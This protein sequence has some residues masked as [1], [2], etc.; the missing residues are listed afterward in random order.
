MDKLKHLMKPIANRVKLVVGKAIVRLIDDEMRMQTMQVEA[1]RGEVLE[2][3][4]RYQQYGFSS[5]PH[6]GSE[7]L[8]LA[9]NGMRQHSVIVAVDDRRHR[10]QMLEEGE[11]A[12]YT[13]LDADTGQRI[14]L[15]RNGS[16]EIH[17]SGSSITV[18]DGNIE[19]NANSVNIT[20]S[21]LTHNGTNVGD[22]HV[23]G[24]IMAGSG[25]TS[26]PQ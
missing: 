17:S 15:K 10:I 8:I 1:L 16:I 13:D 21:S 25:S 4:E 18:S 5:H 24:G 23:H 14:V 6:T 9:L 12:L 3:L 26:G 20:S 22:S 11:V 2:G 19:L 7:A